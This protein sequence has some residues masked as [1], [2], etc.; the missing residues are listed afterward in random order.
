MGLF[1]ILAVGAFL[2]RRVPPAAKRFCLPFGLFFVLPNLFPLT[3]HVWDSNKLLAYWV[4]GMSPAIGCLLVELWRCREP[5]HRAATGAVVA[6]VLLAGALD[7]FRAVTPGAGEY[8]QFD[9]DVE[10]IALEIRARTE[11]RARILTGPWH[12]SPVFLAGRKPFLGAIPY[13]EALGIPLGGRPEDLRRM[14]RGGP[15]ALV[16]IRRHALTYALISDSEVREFEANRAFF[17][18]QFRRIAAVGPWTLYD[19]RGGD[20]APGRAGEAPR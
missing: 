3:P 9:Q 16:L 7:A 6:S 1:P 2:S 5:F 17:D 14:F 11:P 18:G 10:G 4:L 12:N 19:L 15:E 20:R 8:G 13:V